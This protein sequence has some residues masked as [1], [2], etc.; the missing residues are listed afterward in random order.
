MLIVFTWCDVMC[1]QLQCSV[2]LVRLGQEPFTVAET[3]ELRLHCN[4]NCI[5][6]VPRLTSEW[7]GLRVAWG[8]WLQ[9]HGLLNV[10]PLIN[11]CSE[12]KFAWRLE[13]IT[14]GNIGDQFEQY[15]IWNSEKYETFAKVSKSGSTL[16]SLILGRTSMCVRKYPCRS[17]AI[18]ISS[19]RF[20]PDQ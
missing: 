1:R 17:V 14:L 18:L 12:Y 11:Q 10:C 4:C 15:W 3:G 20:V 16:I 2:L 13:K 5:R 9:R 6:Q 8:T 19:Q 7:V